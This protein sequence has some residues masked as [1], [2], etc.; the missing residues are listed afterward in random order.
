MGPA[1]HSGYAGAAKTIT[2]N[3]NAKLIATEHETEN[4]RF[5]ES[6]DR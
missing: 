2:L 3:A 4:S 1:V 5:C 6:T